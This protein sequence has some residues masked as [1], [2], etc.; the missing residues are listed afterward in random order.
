MVRDIYQVTQNTIN[1]QRAEI[2]SLKAAAAVTARNDTLGAA[3]TPEI[4]VLFPQVRDIAIVRSIVSNV[5]TRMLDTVNVALVQYRTP[6]PHA[7]E[8]KFKEYLQAR[9][10]YNEIQIVAATALSGKK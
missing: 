9:L 6:M 4:K 7:Q 1:A 2:D 5:D 3:V 10:G 8:V